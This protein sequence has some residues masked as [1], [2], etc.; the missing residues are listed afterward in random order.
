M[1]VV[2]V[3][4]VFCLS[5]CFLL[6]PIHRQPFAVIGGFVSVYVTKMLAHIT[7]ATSSIGGK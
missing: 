3:I 6:S 4:V 5:V 7:A 1:V 2:V